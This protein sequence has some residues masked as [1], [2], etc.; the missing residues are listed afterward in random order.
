MASDGVVIT[1]ED[2]DR[3]H[4]RER[5][6]TTRTQ[7]GPWSRARLLWL[8]IGPGILVMLGENDGPSM[9]SYAATGARYGI[10]FF[11][12]FVVLTFVMACVVQ[13]MTVRLGAATHRGHAELIFDRFGPF[14]GWS[15]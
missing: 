13:E 2:I 8:L 1:H 15:R 14:W 12:P 4:D 9:L 5:V 7:R 11:L 10:G 6:L 3:A